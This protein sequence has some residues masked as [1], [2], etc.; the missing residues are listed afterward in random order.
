MKKFY[1]KYSWLIIILLLALVVFKTCNSEPKPVQG[2]NLK[3]EI[4]A[5]DSFRTIIKYKDSVR[6][7]EVLKWRNMTHIT[8]SVKCYTEII[9]FIAQCDTIILH[10]SIL[11]GT[12]DKALDLDSTIQNKLI[13]R[14]SQDSAKIV[15]LEKKVKRNRNLAKL[16]FFTGTAL[17]AFIGIK[18]SN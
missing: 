18:A 7:K 4:K 14:I 16:S 2:I 8:D 5:Q 6:I 11:I 10:D 1:D 12:M 15:K 13:N 9:P 3:P 17:G